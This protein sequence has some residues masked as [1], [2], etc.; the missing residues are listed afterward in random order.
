MEPNKSHTQPHIISATTR[1]RLSRMS[2]LGCISAV[3]CCLIRLSVS[4]HFER[5]HRNHDSTPKRDAKLSLAQLSQ[6][7]RALDP[8]LYF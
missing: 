6:Q 2:N 4:W 8:F 1:Q 3:Q 7:S 5:V